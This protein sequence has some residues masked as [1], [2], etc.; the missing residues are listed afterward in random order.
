M[1]YMPVDERSD[2]TARFYLNDNDWQMDSAVKA[3]KGDLE[4]ERKNRIQYNAVKV[5]KYDRK[6]DYQE[7]ELL[8]KKGM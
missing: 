7:Q 6:V 1:G 8:I 2:K 4:W 3:F 5:N